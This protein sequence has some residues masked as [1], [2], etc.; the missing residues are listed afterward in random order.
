MDMQ[1]AVSVSSLLQDISASGGPPSNL[2]DAARYWSSAVHPGM[3]RQDV[4]ALVWLL[5]EVSGHRRVT[6]IDREAARFWA[7]RL[8]A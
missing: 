4:Q 8:S 6:D 7:T 1:D 2:R 3:R 5:R